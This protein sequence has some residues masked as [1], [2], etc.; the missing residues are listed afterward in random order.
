MCDGC[1]KIINDKKTAIRSAAFKYKNDFA[2]VNDLITLIHIKFFKWKKNQSGSI[3]VN[4]TFFY[5]T[6]K[7]AAID[8]VRE[9]NTSYDDP[10]HRI[11]IEKTHFND[12]SNFALAQIIL[13]GCTEE[14]RDAL[15]SIANKEDPSDFAKRYDITYPNAVQKRRR[16]LKKIRHKLFSNQMEARNG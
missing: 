16:V 8:E 3:S 13:S 6:A 7:R 1:E 2:E 14:E 9:Y 11:L 10:S 15:L 5:T 4:N 12:P